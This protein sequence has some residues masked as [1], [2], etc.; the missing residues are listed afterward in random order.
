AI[1][2]ILLIINIQL[3]G[4]GSFA[5]DLRVALLSL[6]LIL[7]YRISSLIGFQA[8]AVRILKLAVNAVRNALAGRKLTTAQ[9]GQHS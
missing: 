5:F 4:T 6:S 3:S 9:V 8:L 2:S 1:G 7:S